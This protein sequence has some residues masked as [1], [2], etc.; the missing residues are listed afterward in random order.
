[1]KIIDNFL[2]KEE[3]KNLQN[4]LLSDI[5]PWFFNGF[6]V[7]EGKDIKEDC[8]QFIYNF[9]IN[10]Y[11]SQYFKIVSPLV[12]KINPLAII[13]LKANL[14]THGKKIIE[15]GYHIDQDDPKNIISSAIFY[16]NDNNG[17]TK[18]ED[19]TKV[20]SVENRL[21][22]FNSSIKHTGTNCTD[23]QRRVILNFNYIKKS[24]V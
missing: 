16:I 2:P 13:R 9:Y 11:P 19:G 8:F 15:H 24:Q 14:T 3:F 17:Y 22:I 7:T 21:V 4:F 1:M 12:E 6:V 5:F 18:F 20:N 23:T 10:G